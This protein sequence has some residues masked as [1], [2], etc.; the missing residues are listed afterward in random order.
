MCTFGLFGI[1][2]MLDWC[3]LPWLVKDIN[4][5]IKEE[6]LVVEHLRARMGPNAQIIVTES[7]V[8][9]TNPTAA[10]NTVHD[11]VVANGA[12]ATGG[13][14]TQHTGEFVNLLFF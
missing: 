9:V 6:N 2:W 13:T 14:P 12:T 1:G 4:E 8:V 3:R 5:K 10:V 11:S 7:S